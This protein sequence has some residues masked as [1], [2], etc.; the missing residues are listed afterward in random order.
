MRSVAGSISK[1]HHGHN[2][3]KNHHGRKHRHHHRDHNESKNTV[4]VTEGD[5]M[6][7][8]YAARACLTSRKFEKVVVAVHDKS[9]EFAQ[10][11]E[12]EGA[13]VKEWDLKNKNSIRHCLQDI[14][15]LLLVP[16]PSYDTVEK[17]RNILEVIEQEMDEDSN[18]DDEDEFELKKLVFWGPLFAALDDER[19]RLDHKNVV[20]I[21]YELERLIKKGPV[22][23]WTIVRLGFMMQTLFALSEVIQNRGVIPLAI[24]E[25][26][27]APVNLKDCARATVTILSEIEND[28]DDD[29]DDE[30]EDS[31]KNKKRHSHKRRHRRGEKRDNEDDEDDDDEDDDDDD[32]E[33]DFER[34]ILTFTGSQLI[35]G[36]ELAERASRGLGSGS[37]LRFEPVSIEE[38]RQILESESSDDLNSFQIEMMLQGMELIEKDKLDIRSHDLQKVLKGREPTTVEKWFEENAAQFKPRGG[39]I[40]RLILQDY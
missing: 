2:G 3:H 11:L 38:M 16:H 6:I 21:A 33:G 1:K 17:T 12:K 34:Q 29:N 13:H 39:R 5:E 25:G 36:E 4:L 14:D 26:E 37:E 31:K 19:R 32:N 24:G 10:T 27:F 20:K 23:D 35:D 40:A 9:H 7:G 30:D 28:D 8:F 22:E 15:C 18:D